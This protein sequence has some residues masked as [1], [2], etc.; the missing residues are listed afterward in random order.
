MGGFTTLTSK[1]WPFA[2]LINK[3]H[4]V[5]IK[6]QGIVLYFFQ[7]RTNNLICFCYSVHCSFTWHWETWHKWAGIPVLA[8]TWHKPTHLA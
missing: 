8:Q 2:F 4:A 7:H 1:F 6:V 3:N 5:S